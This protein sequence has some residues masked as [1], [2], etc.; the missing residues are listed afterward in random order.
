ME[1][2]E[3]QVYDTEGKVVGTA[4]EG[5]KYITINGIDYPIVTHTVHVPTYI[6]KEELKD[7]LI[8]ASKNSKS[9]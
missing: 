5:D 2:K 9:I 8:E 6:N 4:Y 3:I 7:A 1:R